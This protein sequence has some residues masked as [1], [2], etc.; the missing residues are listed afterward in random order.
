MPSSFCFF[1][2]K[3]GVGKTTCACAFALAARRDR[4]QGRVLVV[5]TDPAHSL[6]D[7]L[8]VTLSSSTRQVARRLDAIELDG[9]R[10]FARWLRDHRHAL[11]DIL[12]HGTWLDRNDVDALMNLS[13]PGIDELVGLLEIARIATTQ[14]Y[15]LIVVDTAPT[16][17]TLRLL[18]A[19]ET[20][21]VVSGVLDALQDDHRLIRDRLARVSRGPEAADRLIAM[22]ASQASD[23]AARLRDRSRTSF[24]WVTLPEMM[25]VN[26]TVDAVAALEG[27]GITV[28]EI[29]VNRVLPR[30]RPCRLCDRRRAEEQRV[31]ATIGRRLGRRRGLR[32]IA[33]E[34]KEPRGVAAL[35]RIGR[36]LTTSKADSQLRGRALPHGPAVSSV[37]VSPSSPAALS[38]IDDASLIFVGGK[39]GVGKTTVA[40]AIALCAARSV[41]T[42]RV[43]LLSTDPAHSLG[44]VLNAPVGDAPATVPRA[45]KNLRVRELDAPR[46]L[47]SR[48]G[49]LEAALNEIASAFGTTE[50][51]RGAEKAR[52]LMELAPP[53]I[54]E[55]F[56]LMSVVDARDDYDLIV[57]DMA[58]TGHAL[59]LLEVPDAAREWTQTLL[60]VLLKYRTLVRP[61]QLAEELVRVA[62]SVRELQTMLRDAGRTRFVVV[63]RAAE[64]PRLETERLVR[65]LGRLQMS[66]PVVVVNALTAASR[67]CVRCRTIAAAERRSLTA[68]RRSLR[69]ARRGASHGCAIIQTPLSA[70]P[71]VGISALEK[72]AGSWIT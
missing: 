4:R 66:P 17:H 44:D 11:T 15:D 57:V 28:D 72:W 46:A 25:S 1:G 20:V 19:P 36:A 18:A 48:R 27:A 7:A 9:P 56:G 59:R 42:R 53:G 40:A 14:R 37:A 21:G 38:A 31:L 45:A 69:L 8:G 16:G 26:E 55:L 35:T 43:L 13:L 41:T 23:T 3:G 62:K 30:G 68:L 29:V 67:L 58:P 50:P 64:V 5:S 39:G 49:D 63:T 47:A 12:E 6:G 61:G 34:V 65:R 33:A 60:R 10:A 2:G 54:D 71:P 51:G 24:R 70:P 22:L 52:E 32:V